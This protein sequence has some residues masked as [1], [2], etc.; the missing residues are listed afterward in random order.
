MRYQ[1]KYTFSVHTMKAMVDSSRVLIPRPCTARPTHCAVN[2][3]S[4]NSESP[5][6]SPSAL[7]LSAI[8]RSAMRGISRCPFSTRY[9]SWWEFTG[10][11]GKSFA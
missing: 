5:R 11:A 6:A 2:H 3:V 1:K 4:C 7:F 8:S 10:K 9:E